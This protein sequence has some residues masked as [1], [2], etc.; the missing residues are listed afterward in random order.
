MGGDVSIVLLEV[1]LLLYQE[2]H[3]ARSL[4][5]PAIDQELEALDDGVVARVE[6]VIAQGVDQLVENLLAE[7]FRWGRHENH[8]VV[9]D[10]AVE[11]PVDGGDQVAVDAE[12]LGIGVVPVG[13][14]P[15]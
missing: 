1:F 10:F 5:F 13:A 8:V 2:L 12:Q 15:E 3:G 11:A 4:V 7:R 9:D 14:A 6:F